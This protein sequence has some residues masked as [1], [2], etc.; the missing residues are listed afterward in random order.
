M[1]DNLTLVF[2]NG[3]LKVIHRKG[4]AFK[5]HEVQILQDLKFNLRKSFL[6]LID[7][8]HIVE[9]RSSDLNMQVDGNKIVV[10]NVNLSW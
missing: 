8:K 1:F 9:M 7:V 5:V 2:I 10:R 3:E 4:K 6:T